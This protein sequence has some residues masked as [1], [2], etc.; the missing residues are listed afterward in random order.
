[1]KIKITADS[2][3]DLEQE[4]IL[5]HDI[6]VTPL[7]IGRSNGQDFYDGVDISTTELFR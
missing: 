7:H 6:T 3:C 5:Q 1:M 4:Q 2:T